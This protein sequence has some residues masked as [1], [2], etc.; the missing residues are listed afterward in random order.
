MI[1]SAVEETSQDIYLSTGVFV[2]KQQQQ[3]RQQ[4]QQ[5]FPLSNLLLSLLHHRHL[6]RFNNLLTKDT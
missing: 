2:P 3:Q 5:Q 6:S 4:Q 1:K